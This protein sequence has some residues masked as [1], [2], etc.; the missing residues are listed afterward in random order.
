LRL[1]LVSVGKLSEPFLQEGCEFFVERVRR[2][3]ALD[4]IVVPEEKISSRGKKK[5]ILQQ[6]GERIRGKI[7]PEV[8]TVAADERGKVLSSEAFAHT[9]DTWS[10][11]GLKEV[12]FIVGG[13]YGLD[14]SLKQKADFR[15]SLSS[16]TLTHGLAKML[17]LE[18]I[19]RAFTIL[20][21]EPYH[22]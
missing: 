5:Y 8:F 20:K 15:L 13:P 22:K 1:T 10:S 19:Y 17:L 14:D 7:R 4:L 3:A 21:G 12:V 16:M 2:Y 18:Q 11:S 9:L 6:E